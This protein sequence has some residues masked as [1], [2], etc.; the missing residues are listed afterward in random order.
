VAATNR[1]LREAINE[2]SFREDFYYRLNVFSIHVEPL[3]KRPDDIPALIEHFLGI[4]CADMG[5]TITGIED[6][7]TNLFMRYPWPGNVRE[8]EHVL[9]RAAVL[10]DGPL[11]TR[12]DIPQDMFFL[13]EQ[14]EP[15]PEISPEPPPSREE[16]SLVERTGHMESEIIRAALEKFHWNKTKTA[17]HLGLKRTTLQY[18]IK[19]Y[20]I[21]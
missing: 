14:P 20:G 9:E 2:G 6:D 17:K 12:E 15:E 5:K 16:A 21:E 18:K 7:V 4:F 1:D 10:T 3:R 11:I 19:K 13:Q 8:L